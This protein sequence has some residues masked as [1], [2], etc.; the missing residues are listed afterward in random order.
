MLDPGLLPRLLQLIAKRGLMPDAM[1]AVQAVSEQGEAEYVVDLKLA[2]LPAM[3]GELMA[4]SM[5]Q[6]PGVHFVYFTALAVPAA[7]AAE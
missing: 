3:T 2:D 6:I 4:E 1:H 5:R 7:V